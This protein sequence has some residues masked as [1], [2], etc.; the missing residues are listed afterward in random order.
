MQ[1]SQLATMMTVSLPFKDIR[2]ELLVLNEVVGG[3]SKAVRIGAQV[4]EKACAV[5]GGSDPILAATSE[6][7]CQL[8]ALANLCRVDLKRSICHKCELNR[9]KYPKKLCV[10]RTSFI[11]RSHFRFKYG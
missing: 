9:E 2:T 6:V 3:L 7:L 1:S 5:G 8:L 4:E 10:V 11:C